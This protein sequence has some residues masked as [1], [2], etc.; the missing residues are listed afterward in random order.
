M[1][2]PGA[3]GERL[4]ARVLE[5]VEPLVAAAAEYRVGEPAD[6]D[7]DV[8]L[9]DGTR[10]VGTVGGLYGHAHRARRVLPA[11]ARSS[12][13]GPGSRL[14]ALTA[15]TGEPWRAV[16]VGR[17]E[18]FGIARAIAGPLP[19]RAGARACS[20]S[21]CAARGRAARAAAAVH[22]HRPRVRPRVRTGAAPPRPTRWP[23]RPGA[24]PT[25]P[26][27]ETRRPRP[28]ARAGAGPRPPSVLAGRARAAGGEPTRFGA[29]ALRLW[30]PLLQ[31][32]TW[33]ADDRRP[34]ARRRSTCCGPLPTGTTVLEASA[35]TG[36]TFTIAA[37]VARYVAEGVARSTSC[38]V[39]TFGR[40][41]D[42]GAARA[43]AR[44]AASAP[45]ARSPTRPHARPATDAVL[46]H[47]ADAPTPRSRCGGAGSRDALADFDAATIATTHQFCQQVLA[48]L[49]VAGDTDPAR[50][51][52]R[53]STT[54]SPRSSTT[55]TCASAATARAGPPPFDRADALRAR[56]APAVERPAGRL[57]PRDA[58]RRRGRRHAGPRSR[59]A[60]RAEVDRRKRRRGVLS[61][62]DLLTRLA[63]RAGRPASGAGRRG[64]LRARY[65]VVLVDEF[66]DTD[67]VQWDDPAPRLPRARRRWC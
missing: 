60:V 59:A 46:A 9:P 33:C 64:R 51:S 67:P 19:P 53:T 17:G 58:E 54:W 57:V 44:A 27:P 38:C 26:V 22:R 39:V 24:G 1:L 6:R 35:G 28:R 8:E 40:A 55:S 37:L 11:R 16:T 47:L 10:V 45:S 15:A 32:R 5:D 30:G 4:L 56:A 34:R 36:K 3:L 43:G 12:G 65:R 66:Q 25:G 48:G 31:W 20:P 63:R 7:V 41:A 42:P 62:D 61:Y 21:W 13:S 52:S 14:V 50:C 49:G 18:R 23:R 2:P 29:L